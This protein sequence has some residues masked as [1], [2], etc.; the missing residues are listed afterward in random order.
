MNNL[1]KTRVYILAKTQVEDI[2]KL[3]DIL[4]Y[5]DDQ[6]NELF[7]IIF[8][9]EMEHLKSPDITIKQL[10]TEIELDEV[11]GNIKCN[12]NNIFKFNHI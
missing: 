7:K 10:L 4:T 1:C 5:I 11:V 6:L 9:E 12:L 2:L 3:V 8:E